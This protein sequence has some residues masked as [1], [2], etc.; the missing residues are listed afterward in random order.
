MFLQGGITTD[1]GVDVAAAGDVITGK[2]IKLLLEVF[3]K[4]KNDTIVM[5]MEKE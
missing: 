5:I 3:D 4:V 1:Y 2:V